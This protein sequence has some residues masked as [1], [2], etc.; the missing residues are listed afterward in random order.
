M[1]PQIRACEWT[2]DGSTQPFAPR[3]VHREV[4]KPFPEMPAAQRCW[5]FGMDD[6]ECV[7]RLLVH[8]KGR[9]P[10]DGQLKTAACTIVRNNRLLDGRRLARANADLDCI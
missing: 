6:R 3:E 4:H 8:K 5:H 1:P 9:M 2:D 10:F 7:L